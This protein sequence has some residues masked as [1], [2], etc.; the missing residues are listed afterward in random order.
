MGYRDYYLFMLCCSIGS[1]VAAGVEKAA[2]YAT[3]QQRAKKE[4]PHT[5]AQAYDYC[6]KHPHAFIAVVWPLVQGKDAELHAIFK[7]HGKLVY[8]KEFFFTY[9][10][11][12]RTLK[13]AHPL[14]AD[15]DDHVD[16]Y[17]PAGTFQQPARIFVV[18]F[19]DAATAI[20]CKME[21]RHLFKLQ[22]RPIHINDYHYETV[23]FAKLFFT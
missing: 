8:R 12:R 2:V 11:A 23:E 14:I 18:E 15:L 13:K 17:F 5:D 21:I 1:G 19:K 3:V 10:T 6:K 22:Y 9:K 7:K 20:A 4:R 16:W